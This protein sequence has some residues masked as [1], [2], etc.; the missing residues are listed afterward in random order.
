MLTRISLIALG[1]VAL[2]MLA[3]CDSTDDT[4]SAFS[5]DDRTITATEDRRDLDVADGMIIGPES[6]EY[7][8]KGKRLAMALEGL[9]FEDGFVQ[10]QPNGRNN[11]NLAL[12]RYQDGEDLL[13][14]NRVFEAIRAY[15]VAIQT[16]PELALP[17]HGLGI[18]LHGRGK[19]DMAIASFATAKRQDPNLLEA[20]FELAMALQMN[21]LLDEAIAEMTELVTLDAENALAHER[22]AIWH[23]YAGNYAK[24]WEHVHA[25][26]DLGHTMPGQF[27]AL[28]EQDMPDPGSSSTGGLSGLR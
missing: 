18:A 11:P 24:A 8:D 21:L 17:Y 2:T 4:S 16:A 19:T 7:G 22:L 20:R 6:D 15:R 13:S 12:R 9:T 25:A 26:Q 27:I 14:R 28:L 1:G 3:G 10:V 23:R 5:A